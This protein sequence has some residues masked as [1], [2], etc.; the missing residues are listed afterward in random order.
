MVNNSVVSSSLQGNSGVDLSASP[1]LQANNDALRE[2]VTFV[3]FAAEKFTI[4]FVS[5][6]FLSDR[7]TI[8]QSLQQH[9]NCQDIQFVRYTFDSENLRFLQDELIQKLS[10]LRREPDKK[11]VLLLTGLEASIKMVGE[12]GD[13][14]P[15]LVDLNYVRDGFTTNV[16]YPMIIFLPDRALSRIA[17]FAP[18][19]WAWR[20][21]VIRF[22]SSSKFVKS[23]VDQFR[24]SSLNQEGEGDIVDKDS[25]SRTNL[26]V[27]PRFLMELDPGGSLA[28]DKEYKSLKSELMA[29]LGISH[30]EQDNLDIA[31]D[32]LIK[33]LETESFEKPKIDK[34][35]AFRYLGMIERQQKNFEE[36]LKRFHQSINESRNLE[37]A[38]SPG[39]KNSLQSAIVGCGKTY[40]LMER[41]S[42]AISDFNRAI[43]LDPEDED[44]VKER[45]KT[46]RLMERYSEAISDFNRAIELDSEDGEAIAHRGNVYGF[47]KCYSEAVSDFDRAIELDPEY[48]WAIVL[49]GHAYTFM[50]RYSEAISDFN[51]V[52]ELDPEYSSAIAHRG[53]AYQA[54]KRYSEA[55]SD[56]NRAIELDPEHGWAIAHRGYTYRLMKRYSEAIADFDRAIELNPE[57]R[58]AIAHRGYTYRLMKRYSE[59]I[60]DF[61][62]A[63]ILDA[64]YRWA[65]A[66]RGRTYRLMER[67]SEA[68][69]DFDYAVELDPEYKW[70]IAQRGKTYQLMEQYSEAIADFG[71]A[72]E[73]DPE[74]EWAIAQRGQT[75]YLTDQ[76]ECAFRD[77]DIATKLDDKDHWNVRKRGEVNLLLG[78]HEKALQDFES[79][80]QLDADNNWTF[81][82]RSLAYRTLQR[83]E[84]AE[85]DIQQAIQLAQQNYEEKPQ[86]YHI[87]NL[88]IY[89]LTAGDI[90]KAKHLYQDA[91]DKASS[92]RIIKEAIRDLDDLL[93]VLPNFPN[94]EELRSYLQSALAARLVMTKGSHKN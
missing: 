76:H 89:H 74:Y 53:H 77:F 54:M 63:I 35:E 92:I 43:E 36:A 20:R 80:L 40:R 91:L 24:R 65:I 55:I 45:G 73:L 34:P 46:Y 17:E 12:L 59:A 70:A 11:I 21:V 38:H 90:S 30:Y 42:E 87:F 19:F 94:A 86:D 48:S 81:Y 62:R 58:W 9:P 37:D 50:E 49:R 31:K 75:H 41:Y 72:V 33:S 71:R 82:E 47:I 5:V 67:Y 13:Y 60:V 28:Q 23:R 68:I 14:P 18:D 44:T 7:E 66:Q 29:K 32:L 57:Y 56:F 26:D 6:N 22:K 79:S 83:V 51:H 10:E 78:N 84:K 85:S 39:F 93:A 61:D 4:G 3:D 1:F 88:A 2:L 16:P 8:V 15:M 27:I 25:I 69:V 64:E 52:I